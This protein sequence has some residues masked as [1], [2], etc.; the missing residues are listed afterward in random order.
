MGRAFSPHHPARLGPSKRPIGQMGRSLSD[1]HS[2]KS[3]KAGVWPTTAAFRW[4]RGV[5]RTVSARQ[6]GPL[7]ELDDLRSCAARRVLHQ[8]HHLTTACCPCRGP[9]PKPP[10]VLAKVRLATDAK[11]MGSSS[12]AYSTRRRQRLT[13]RTLGLV[14]ANRGRHPIPVAL[15]FGDDGHTPVFPTRSFGCDG[16]IAH[17]RED[18]LRPPRHRVTAVAGP[19]RSPSS[20]GP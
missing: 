1:L 20:P 7:R 19:P 9:K 3:A 6:R 14:P 11:P 2:P 8:M 4:A 10:T 13:L 18:N 17:I 5:A 12:G 16:Q 15:Q